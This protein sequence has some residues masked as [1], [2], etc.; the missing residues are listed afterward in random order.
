MKKLLLVLSFTF[1]ACTAP[2][3]APVVGASP[4]PAPT[5]TPAPSIGCAAETAVAGAIA[6]VAAPVCTGTAAIQAAIL[7]GLGKADLC[8]TLAKARLAAKYRAARGQSKAAANLKGTVGNIAC[9]LIIEDILPSGLT[10]IPAIY[11]CSATATVT[12]LESAATTACE[13]AIKF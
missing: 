4:T 2:T 1:V 7:R 5:A 11:G 8:P 3:P 12:S 9:P 13:G 6:A 10:A